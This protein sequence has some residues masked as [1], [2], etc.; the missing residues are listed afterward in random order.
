MRN[1]LFLQTF[2]GGVHSD[3]ALAKGDKRFKDASW[4]EEPS[5]HDLIERGSIK[6]REIVAIHSHARG[7]KADFTIRDHH[8]A[9]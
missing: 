8:F 4:T 7:L 6:L 1:S 9:F 3:V 2:Q 5:Q